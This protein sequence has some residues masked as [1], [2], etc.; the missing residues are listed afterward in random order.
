MQASDGYI[1]T[2]WRLCNHGKNLGYNWRNIDL[3]DRTTNITVQLALYGTTMYWYNMGLWYSICCTWKPNQVWSH[4]SKSA[5]LVV[6]SSLLTEGNPLIL[7]TAETA[8]LI[9][10]NKKDYWWT[11]YVIMSNSL[12]CCGTNMPL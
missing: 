12:D 10:K 2:I 7:Y 8:A 3:Q 5:V 4:S 9:Y 1:R 6:S 11:S